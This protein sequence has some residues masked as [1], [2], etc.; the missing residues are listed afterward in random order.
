MRSPVI[1]GVAL[2]TGTAVSSRWIVPQ[3]NSSDTCT[4]LTV[5]FSRYSAENRTA[6]FVVGSSR[7]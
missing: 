6:C 2:I 5:A 3:Q 7:K 1:E 4:I